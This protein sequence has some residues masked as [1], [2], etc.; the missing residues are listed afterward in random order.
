MSRPKHCTLPRLRWLLAL[1]TLVA[2]LG[3]V[4]QQPRQATKA[5]Q[6]L[7]WAAEIAAAG[8][9]TCVVTN[10]GN[11]SCWGD[12]AYGQMGVGSTNPYGGLSFSTYGLGAR[13]GG[14]RHFCSVDSAYSFRVVCWGE[15][16]SGQLGLPSSGPN[17]CQGT[18][19]CRTFAA[20][21]STYFVCTEYTCTTP[22]T[23]VYETAAGGLHSCALA[24]IEMNGHLTAHSD[25]PGKGAQFTL[26]IPLKTVT[27]EA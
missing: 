14:G 23:G 3:A 21:G 11:G 18:V 4:L 27:E 12:N 16:S 20:Q 1:L 2:V 19:P 24:A 17:L 8:D 13:S 9:T 26:Q 25:G 6:D 5:L 10:A 7:E 15:N 22:L